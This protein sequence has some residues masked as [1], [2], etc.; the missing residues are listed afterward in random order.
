MKYQFTKKDK[1]EIK[2]LLL[3]LRG[4]TKNSPIKSI[5]FLRHKKAVEINIERWDDYKET[6]FSTISCRIKK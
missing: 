2:G 5:E 6:E 3:F 4:A 1:Q